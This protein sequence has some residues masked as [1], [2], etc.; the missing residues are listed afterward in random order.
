MSSYENQTRL[1]SLA[2]DNEPANLSMGYCRHCG[3]DHAL[4]QNGARGAC[5]ELMAQFTRHGCIDFSQPPDERDPACR[6]DSLF[7]E[8]GG[9]MFGAL[10]GEC[11]GRQVIAFAFSGQFNGLWS[12]PG[13]VDPIFNVEAYEELAA[14]HEE[15]EIKELGRRMENLEKGD[16]RRTSLKRTRKEKSRRLMGRIHRLYTLENFQGESVRLVDA[17]PGQGAPPTGTGDCC[18]PKLLHHA[19]LNGIRPTGMA[20]FYWGRANKS[21]TRE[22]G[23]FYPPCSTRCEPILGFLLCGLEG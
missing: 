10:V 7:G 13:W 2:G 5:L 18:A 12:V 4:P 3:R 8:A 14:G 1:I 11:A 23:C 21:A 6:L 15:R 22:H 20:E 19:V 17:F 16:P 9:K